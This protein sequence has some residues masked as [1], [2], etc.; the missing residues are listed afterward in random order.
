MAKEQ[1]NKN[2]KVGTVVEALPN[3]VFKVEIDNKINNGKV[4]AHLSGKMR[5][6]HIKV[7]VGDTVKIE[8]G[9]YDETKG[10]IIQRL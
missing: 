5:M 2:I 8:L 4:M 10:R 1:Q 7:L 6:N 9:L 3:A